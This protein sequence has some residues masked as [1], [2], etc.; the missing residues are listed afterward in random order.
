ML[1]KIVHWAN[2]QDAIRVVLLTSSRASKNGPTDVLSDYD[3][4]LFVSALDKFINNDKRLH[5]FGKILVYI[6]E[7]II[8]FNQEIPTRLVIYEDGTKVDF[9]LS[10]LEILNTVLNSPTLPDWLDI[11]YRV[12]IDKD[13]LTQNLKKPSLKAYIPKKPTE[14]EYKFIVKKFWWETT[15]VAKNLW[16]DELL[17]AKYSSDSVIRCKWLVRMLEW[18]IQ[19]YNNWECST[20]VFGKG[21]KKLL[22]KDTWVQLTETF[23]GSDIEEN[24]DALFKTMALFRKIATKVANDLGYEYPCEL[25]TKVTNYLIK[26]K[27]LEK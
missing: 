22:D 19:T 23:A 26:I 5:K 14:D 8:H 13:N 3:I 15:Y 9:S 25:D 17:P 27:N 10:T 16:R 18:Y 6:P 4:T 11:G 20:G 2:K 1:D 21:I 7:S 24:W 12:L